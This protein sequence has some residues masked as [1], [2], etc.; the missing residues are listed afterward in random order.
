M[1]LQ[2]R[3]CILRKLAE[4]QPGTPKHDS[5]YK[6][7]V[8]AMESGA[9]K[10]G[11]RLPTET[12]L[13]QT[14]PVSLGTIQR[15]MGS[16]VSEGWVMRRRGAGS[17]VAE[18]RKLLEQPLHCRFVG[19]DGFLPVYAQLV[20][21]KL[22]ATRGPWSLPL[23]QSGQ[24]VLRIERKISINRE[25][26]VLSRIYVDLLRFPLLLTCAP[27]ELASANVKLLLKTHYRVSLSHIEQSLHLMPLPASVGRLLSA[28]PTAAG[29][30]LEL[31]A[32]QT[33]GKAA[34]YQELYVPNNPYRLVVSE[35][36][37]TAQWQPAQFS[38]QAAHRAK[39]P[40]NPEETP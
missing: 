19:P 16:L 6:G 13:A 31:L 1:A 35:T 12:Q 9:L 40:F 29:A 17:F 37:S 11:Q 4:P 34:L 18:P 26:N 28:G 32:V 10:A 21:R 25:F 20:S 24:S 27:A 23:D 36:F 39:T 38:E 14:L 22:I 33:N 15:A 2:W 30:R 5:L 8:E 3:E 7:F